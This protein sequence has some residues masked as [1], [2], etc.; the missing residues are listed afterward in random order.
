MHNPKEKIMQFEPFVGDDQELYIKLCVDELDIDHGNEHLAELFKK[1]ENLFIFKINTYVKLKNKQGDGGWNTVFGS[2]N[3]FLNTLSNEDKMEL[4]TCIAIM[5]DKC[6]TWFMNQNGNMCELDSFM[7]ELGG[8]LN[9]LDDNI[10]LCT[11]LREYV[12]NYMPI[13]LFPDAG[14]RAQDSED[15]TFRPHEVITL[16]MITLLC[17][18][19]CPIFSVL[20]KNLSMNI[21]NKYKE[22][23][24]ATIFTTLFNKS[25]QALITKLDHY[26]EHIVKQTTEQTLSALMHGLNSSSL[27]LHLRSHLLIRQFVNVD[28]SIKDGNL[29]TYIMVSAKR[30]LRTI[31]SNVN[32]NP[33]FTRKPITTKHEDDG[34]TAQIEIDSMTSR[35]LSDTRALIM[36]AATDA[37]RKYLNMYDIEPEAFEAVMSYYRANPIRP[38]PINQMMCSMFYS[39]DIGGGRSMLYMRGPEF[40]TLVALLQMILVQLDSNYVSLAHAMTMLPATNNIMGLAINDGQFSLNVGSTEA[41]RKC[42][43]M[44]EA[45]QFGAR[46]R[47]WDNYIKELVEQY[48]ATG[49]VYNTAPWLWDWLETDNKNGKLIEPEEITIVAICSFYEWLQEVRDLTK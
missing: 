35:K 15:L 36:V 42:R 22:Q 43:N 44:M 49:N 30:A 1:N 21:E 16:M 45:S 28:L 48:L 8:L 7:R 40:N 10:N 5:H 19:F 41:Y 26:I 2:V 34:N 6:I 14:E 24:C 39:A 33:T 29:M 3:A 38:T 37:V 9:L 20:M 27:T 32:K 11:K 12:V 47:D 18:M 17:K 13:G 4:A 46:G 31:H 25:H 23:Y